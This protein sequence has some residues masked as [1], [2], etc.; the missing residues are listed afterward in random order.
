MLVDMRGSQLIETR[1]GAPPVAPTVLTQAVGNPRHV[2]DPNDQIR[3]SP[4]EAGDV[5]PTVQ[6]SRFPNAHHGASGRGVEPTPTSYAAETAGFGGGHGLSH[7]I[8]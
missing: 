5:V 2:G 6:L 4:P 8:T 3:S 1:R 7:D